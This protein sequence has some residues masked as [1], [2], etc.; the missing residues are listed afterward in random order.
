MANF[1][2]PYQ[3]YVIPGEDVRELDALAASYYSEFTPRTPTRRFLVDQL[4]HCEWNL[5]RYRGLHAALLSASSGDPA[6]IAAILRHLA[7]LERSYRR[8]LALLRECR[9]EPEPPARSRHV[10]VFPAA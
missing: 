7:A 2:S 9:P 5:R 8:S 6:A 3:R 10:A 1:A 4:I